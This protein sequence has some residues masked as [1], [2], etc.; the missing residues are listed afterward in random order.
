[1]QLHAA[2]LGLLIAVSSPSFGS[3]LGPDMAQDIAEFRTDAAADNDVGDRLRSYY[4]DLNTA[5]IQAGPLI[6]SMVAA[7]ET[8]RAQ[9]VGYE[10]V[11]RKAD[12]Y[13]EV[14]LIPNISVDLG[15]SPFSVNQFGMR[16]RASLTREKPPNTIRIALVGSSIVMGYG[17]SDDEVF[18][19]LF[20]NRLNTRRADPSQLFEVLNFGVGKQWAPHR[21]VSLQ[22]NV[23]TFAPDAVYYFAHQ[24]E[25]T[26]VASHPAKLLSR[27]QKLPSRHLTE[28][29]EKAGLTSGM[30]WGAIQS[31]LER[32]QPDL[33]RAVYKSIVDEC[34]RR[35][36]VP[37][38]VYLP[39]P[40]TTTKDP[41]PQLLPIAEDSGFIVCDLSDWGGGRQLEDLFSPDDQLHPDARGHR[42][43]ADALTRMVET[44][45]ETL[46]RRRTVEQ[47]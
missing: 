34:R 7:D 33:L 47:P 25:F 42:L 2:G 36:A 28:V 17:V 30:A 38:Y 32:H 31:R 6:R 9:A 40:G 41:E 23:S 27:R 39:I 12:N 21:L 1:V 13:Q 37:V 44:R 18:G 19:R 5:P 29:A 24:D 11:S 8:R 35:G 26:A 4:E 16:D 22:R 15:G 14:E 10:K 43:I 20:E 3:L 46:P 45:P